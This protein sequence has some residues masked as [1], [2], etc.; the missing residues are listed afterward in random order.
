MN[1]E[2]P[3]EVSYNRWNE[4]LNEFSSKLLDTRRKVVKGNWGLIC[5][6]KP[7][8]GAGVKGCWM[9]LKEHIQ[10]SDYSSDTLWTAPMSACRINSNRLTYQFVG[11]PVC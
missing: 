1:D 9:F 6:H 4:I 11:G 8:T 5:L 10:H 2:I 7:Y 3:V